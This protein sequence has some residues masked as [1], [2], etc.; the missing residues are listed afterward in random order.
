MKTSSRFLRLLFLLLCLLLSFSQSLASGDE[1]RAVT[2]EEL[3]LK[4][5]QVEPDADA[6]A[7]FWEVRID[8][9]SSEDLSLQ[10]YVRVKIFTDRGREKYG[11][12]DIPFAKGMK[13]KDIAARVTKPDGSAIEIRKED[14]FER[15]IIRANGL[16]IKAKSF[17]V[18][19][20]EPGVIVEYRYKEVF[21]DAQASGMHLKFQRD[22]PVQSLSYYYKPYNKKKPNYQTFNFSGTEFIE[23]QNGF[24]VA[25]RKNVPALKEE[26]RMP[27]E[28]QVVPW[29][30]LQSVRINFNVIS[31][32]TFAISIKDPGNPELY[33]AGVGSDKSVVT[34]FMNKPDKEIKR[35]AEEITASATTPQEKLQKLYDYCQTQIQNL[36]FDTTATDEQRKK[37]EIKSIGDVLKH[38]AAKGPYIDMLFGAMANALGYETR[39][40]FSANRNEVFFRPEMTNES[41]IHP[42][43]IAVYLDKNWKLYNPG[44]SFLPAGTLV[45]YEEGVWA[46]LV[47]E[48]HSSWLKTPLSDADKSVAK[49]RARLKLLED[50]SLDGEVRIED[51]GQLA[52]NYKWENHDKSANKREEDFKDD[53]K[54]RM[55][56]AEISDLTIENV[57]D[58]NK[59][60]VFAFKIH[61]P[62]YAQKTGKRLFVQPS[63]FEY[64]EAPLFSSGSRKYDVYFHYPWS[65]QD[66]IEIQLPTGYALDSPDQPGQVNSGT[67]SQY[68][69]KISVRDD[70]KVLVYQ[71]NF[72]FGKGGVI[73]FPKGTYS[74][75]KSLFDEFSKRD[76]LAITLKQSVAGPSN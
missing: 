8:D 53:I 22:I 39:I 71:R 75:L 51:T 27:P 3:A 64:G 38:K 13:I 76:S 68:E 24:W 48:A 18:P 65:E 47:G 56:T 59:P 20:L 19:G 23:G 45:W 57:T 37:S 66:D 70:G 58:P 52:L 63:F 60:V 6:E 9:S 4:S 62:A 72:F 67:M 54:R 40:A 12:F 26:P 69:P 61:V 30:L 36:S 7:I 28:D 34:K 50:G 21:S 55:S 74:Q 15:E 44:V 25:T 42:A 5:P 49:R 17:T 31:Y 35:V 16:K 73:L 11:K 2:P 43:A 1:W 29:M 41:F 46:L 32:N 10:H 14:V 33:W